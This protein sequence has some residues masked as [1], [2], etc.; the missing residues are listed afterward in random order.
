MSERWILIEENR[1]Y[2]VSDLGR[3]RNNKTGRILKP[4]YDAKGYSR[5]NLQGKDYRTH[6]LVAKH[7]LPPP[8]EESKFQVNHINGNPR[9]NRVDNLEWCDNSENALH[10]YRLGMRNH[11]LSISDREV[12]YIRSNHLNY[13]EVMSRYGISQ[14]HASAIVNGTRRKVV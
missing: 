4:R 14:S 11:L 9:D 6:R 7:F 12:T 13:R 1:N 2:S 3:V 10:A 5:A 8:S